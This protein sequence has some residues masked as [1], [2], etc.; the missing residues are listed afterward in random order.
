[1]ALKLLSRSGKKGSLNDQQSRMAGR[2]ALVGF[3]GTMLEY[4]DFIIYGAAAALIFPRVFFVNLDPTSATL[5]SLLSFG[6]G[7]VA[8]PVGA[9]IIGH[10]GDRLGR[11]AVLLF[12]LYLMGGSTVAIGLLPDAHMIG[13]AAPVLLTFLRL[14]HGLS[15]A[16]E[17]SGSNSL[18]LE[19]SASGNRAFFTSWTLTGTQAGAILATLIFIPVASLPEEQLLSWGWRIPFLLSFVVLVVAYLIR[20]TMPETPAFAEIREKHE[21]AHFPVVA[22]LRDYWSDV[23]RVIVCALI[24]TVSTMTAV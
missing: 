20:R 17:Q 3:V 15:A 9:I 19:H 6:I 14:L 16:G 11:K 8:R 24:A 13:H 23:L 10:Y 1:M 4:Y 2:A 21:L 7:F 22:L 5:L 18:T 12:T